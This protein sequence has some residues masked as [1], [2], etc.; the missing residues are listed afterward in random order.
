MTNCQSGT[1]GIMSDDEYKWLTMRS[2]G[3][4]GLT[5]T[6]A[7][8]VQRVGQGFPGQMGCFGDEHL[9]GLTRMASGIRAAGSVSSL[10]I[11]HGGIRAPQELTGVQ[12]T[13]PSSDEETGA[14][15]LELHEVEQVREDFIAAA[16]RAEKA[17]FD[18]VQIHGAHGYLICAFLSPGLNRREDMYGGSE[19]GRSRLLFEII[20]GIRNECG[21]DFQLGVRLSPDGYGLDPK[22]MIDLARDLLVDP[23]IDHVD[24][25][26]WDFRREYEGRT[27]LSHYT[28]LPREGVRLGC[29]GALR[30]GAD[31]VE[32]LTAGVDFVSIGKSAILH[33]DWAKRV[34]A[35]PT[36]VPT[37]LPV[38][39]EYLVSEGV[40]PKF[41]DYM[42]KWKGFVANAE[43]N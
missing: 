39:V 24:M 32:A 41:V 9:E 20:Q 31:S 7:S 38:S 15:E 30:T 28:E 11:H 2:E 33:H 1:D 25:S 42:S 5:M 22:E 43:S 36:V 6:C 35:D 27:L 10:Q 12:P 3:G 26:L 21:P 17:G 34:L 4:F 23:R 13:G 18:G 19:R 16:I 8:H 40:G 14:R 29:A 37:S